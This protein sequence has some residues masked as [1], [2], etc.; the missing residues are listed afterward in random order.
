MKWLL[1]LLALGLLG[2]NNESPQT[3]AASSKLLVAKLDT[4]PILQQDPAYQELAQKYTAE[5]IKL[6]QSMEKKLA[7]GGIKGDPRE[8]YLK[9]QAKLNDKWMKQTNDFI[10]TR[11]TKMREVVKALCEEKKIDMVLI[12]SKAYRTVAY[13]AFDITQDVL[14]KIYG[15]PNGPAATPQGTPK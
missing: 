8:T 2:C 9:E 1:P 15:S 10:Q 12:D 14:M 11:H 13:G 3:P 6:R 5:N 7:D 4:L